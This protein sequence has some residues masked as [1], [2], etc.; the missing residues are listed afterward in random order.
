MILTGSKLGTTD[1]EMTGWN[2]SEDYL[3]YRD[4]GITFTNP[5]TNFDVKLEILIAR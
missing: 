2:L 1:S 5:H 4:G 3:P